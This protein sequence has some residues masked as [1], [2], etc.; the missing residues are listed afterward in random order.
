L[1]ESPG[2]DRR[3]SLRGKRRKLERREE[4]A[5]EDRRESLRG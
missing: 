1:I 4:K 2:E 5:R 3:E